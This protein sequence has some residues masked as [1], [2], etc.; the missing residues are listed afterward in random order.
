[1]LITNRYTIF[2]VTLQHITTEFIMGAKNSDLLGRYVWQIDTIRSHG[3][4]TLAEINERWKHSRLGYGDDLPKR[5]FN[6]HRKAI[7]DVFGVY[8]ECDKKHGYK[9]YIDHPEDLEGDSFRT[10]LIDSYATLNQLKADR[11]LEH[12]I[13]FEKMPSGSR[14]LTR[15]LEAMRFNAAVK[16]THQGFDRPMPSTFEVEPYAVK[17]FNR[18]WYLIGRS[19]YTNDVRIYALDR[20][21]DV[22]MTKKKFKMPRRFDLDEFFE[23]C[24]GVIVDRET[25]IERVVIK[26]YDY[27]RN[28]LATLPIHSS[29]KEIAR[30]EESVT[31]SYMVRPNYE[32][33][34]ALLM[35][36]DQIEVVEPQ[37]VRDEMK[38]FAENILAYY[39]D[40]NRPIRV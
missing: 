34:Q 14:F 40:K 23:G 10:W 2:Y 25:P 7:A 19:V 11:T 1:M 24:V 33:L 5:T 30:D 36:G 9:Y 8:I 6:N 27:A 17:V 21:K 26:V 38:Q 22:E 15:I 37:W 29:Q 4:I 39:T 3:R 16:I 31:Y 18:R 35:Q 13:Q 12:R 32:F 28:Y 20:I